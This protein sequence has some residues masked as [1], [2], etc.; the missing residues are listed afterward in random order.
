MKEN[1][2]YEVV[3]SSQEEPLYYGKYSDLIFNKHY[4]K[5]GAVAAQATKKAVSSTYNQLRE[6]VADSSRN[7]NTLLVGKVQSGKT[8]NLE[9]LTALAFD[10]DY[11]VM[12][13]YGGYDKELLS[14]TTNR[15]KAT[16]DITDNP[17]RLNDRDC[18]ILFSSDDNAE[19]SISKVDEYVISRIL[20]KKIPIIFSV[21]KNSS[22]L[23]TLIELLKNVDSALINAF[24]IDDEGDQASLNNEKDKVSSSSSTYAAICEMKKVLNN[25]LYCSVTATPQA[26]IFL[27]DISEL[28][29]DSVHLLYPGEGYCGADAFH[30]Q[31]NDFI[32]SSLEEGAED[33]LTVND[34]AIPDS[35]KEAV[36]YFLIASVLM[37]RRGVD[38]S[39][40]IIHCDKTTDSHS[41]VYSWIDIYAQTLKDS[42]CSGEMSEYRWY[43]EETYKKFFLDKCTSEDF[44]SEEFARAMAEVLDDLLIVL[45][46]GKDVVTRSSAKYYSHCIYIGA[47]LLQRGLTF[48][49]LVV[50]YFTRWAK[51]GGNMDTN[52]QR[53][54]WFGYRGKIFDLSKIFTTETIEEE[55]VNLAYMEDDLWRQF[56][57]VQHNQ[58]SMS[59]I[60]VLAKGS[61]R[62]K[63][64]RNTVVN[65]T[66]FKIADWLRQSEGVFDRIT[67]ESNNSFVFQ[68]IDGLDFE[69]RS[70]ARR[71]KNEND[72][73]VACADKK[74]VTELFTALKGVYSQDFDKNE[75]LGEFAKANSIAIVLMNNGKQRVRAFYNGENRNRIKVLQQGRSSGDSSKSAYLGDNM[76]VVPGYDVTIQLHNIV[77]K[78]DID[79][80]AI[81][82]YDKC[83]SMFAVYISGRS[84]SGYMRS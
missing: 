42:L 3:Q 25:P 56:E 44:L 24:I 41:I 13:I 31:D 37:C 46:N 79:G 18:P 33:I 10:N 57:A 54:R 7:N 12:I 62:Q 11:N 76:A 52:L 64:T 84:K 27:D 70:L 77:P 38:S 80:S 65:F 39:D 45:Q 53:A 74:A 5:Y 49:N 21:L 8:S 75:L 23:N 78:H 29:P 58:L 16:F 2:V 81:C 82:E 68:F 20:K 1:D 83:Q 19:N 4:R 51:S 71:D 17:G 47:D 72:C 61:T 35:L 15:F 14:Q 55:F 26:N 63:P 40:M 6:Q 9:L 69:P 22:R 43:F 67:L 28:R 59:D 66:R 30:L 50:T 32:Y 60:I 73:L 36:R 34:G 48:E